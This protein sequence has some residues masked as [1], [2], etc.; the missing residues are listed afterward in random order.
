MVQDNSGSVS[1]P[2]SFIELASKV[3]EYLPLNLS[4]ADTRA[5]LIDPVLRILGY[6]GARDLRREVPIPATKEFL[7]YELLVNG[8]PRAIV[9]AKALRF[10]LTDAHVG[11]CVEYA[12]VLGVRWCLIT[13]GAA[14]ALY[15]AHARVPLAQKR[16]AEVRLDGDDAATQQAWEMLSLF[17]RED[18]G[19]MNPLVSLLV[20]RVVA[21]ELAR[22]DSPAVD[23]LRRAINARF[24]ERVPGSAVVA[25]IGRRLSNT[26]GSTPG[27]AG[28]PLGASTTAARTAGAPP[29]GLPR[30]DGVA[31]RRRPP[32]SVTL[33][34]LVQAGL[35]PADAALEARVSGV[36][37]AARL[38]DGQIE[39]NGTL[40]SSP[41]AA[42]M[43]LRNTQSWNGWIDWRHRGETLGALRAKLGNANNAEAA[44]RDPSN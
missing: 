24:G 6:E 37:H 2:V 11:Q 13:N 28:R 9:E 23:A 41:S 30:G 18:L 21:D 25:A 27:E 7:D 19:Q 39:L 44:G 26:V 17:S 34:D 22:P 3:S 29:S 35:L 16:V 15:D 4:E 31:H 12:A 1:A 10:A 36:S 14:W 42:S 32:A 8:E 40:Y 20:E 5:H 33:L 43:A 38:R